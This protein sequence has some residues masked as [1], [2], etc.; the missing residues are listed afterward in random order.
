VS[1]VRYELEFYIPEDDIL[2]SH[3]RQNLKSYKGP[4]RFLLPPSRFSGARANLHVVTE[5][6]G[7]RSQSWFRHCG[8]YRTVAGSISHEVIAFP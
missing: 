3:R 8:T 4:L 6:A 5:L 7:T 1:P 2:H